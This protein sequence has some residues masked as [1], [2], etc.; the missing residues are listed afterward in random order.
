MTNHPKSPT[1]R[2]DL[3]LV[4]RRNDLAP[5]ATVTFDLVPGPATR[6]EIAEALG[7]MKLRK[8][9]FSGVLR[10]LGR[11]DWE[12]VADLGA[13]VVQECVVSLDPVATRIDERVER[14][15]MTDY[16]EPEGE[17]IETPEDENAEALG[18]VI[19]VGAVAIEALALAL[20]PFPRARDASLGDDG[21]L[22]AAPDGQ[23]PLAD[24]DLRPFAALAGLRKRMDG[25][26]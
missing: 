24:A 10:P 13:S 19:D 11:K 15:F 6:H 1:P 14:R 3:A 7:L 16:A 8:L 12:L 2:S 20:P 17:D 18:S 21:A 22:R 4:L 25:K 5:R 23:A 26:E 9:R